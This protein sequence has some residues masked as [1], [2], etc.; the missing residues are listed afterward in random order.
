MTVT[1]STEARPDRR[2]SQVATVKRAHA[3]ALPWTPQDDHELRYGQGKL[4]ERAARLGRT[5]Y[6]AQL[7]LAKLR[8]L[9]RQGRA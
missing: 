8:K 1:T 6:A 7:R 2:A 4:V 5:Y 3:Y 9:D